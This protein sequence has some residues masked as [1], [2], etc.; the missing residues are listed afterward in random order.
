[1]PTFGFLSH[2]FAL[3]DAPGD[4]IEEIGN[5]LLQHLT[6]RYGCPSSVSSQVP[7]IERR[8]SA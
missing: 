2:D 4:L 8:L 1:M 7:M 6:N 5:Q 3:Q